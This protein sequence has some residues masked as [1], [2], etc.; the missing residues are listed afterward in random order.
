MAAW[1]VPAE[2][3]RADTGGLVERSEKN[4]EGVS[5][6]VMNGIVGGTAVVVEPKTA[7]NVVPRRLSASRNPKGM[8]LQ[9]DQLLIV[10]RRALR[11]QN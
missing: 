7:S 10:A 4:M 1:S 6:D 9:L 2:I 8:S 5:D 3:A 11:R